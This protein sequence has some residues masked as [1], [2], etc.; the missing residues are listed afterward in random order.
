[1]P[2]R[3]NAAERALRAVVLGRKNYLH[4]GPDS[5]GERQAMIYTLVAIAELNGLDLEAYL[6]Y[7][8][9]RNV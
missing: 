8:I 7:V 1:M 2:E 3:H 5:V 6:R 9:A 4:F